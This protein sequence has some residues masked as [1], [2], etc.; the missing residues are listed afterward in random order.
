M[1]PELKTVLLTSCKISRDLHITE[2]D[3]S[4]VLGAVLLK[5]FSVVNMFLGILRELGNNCLRSTLKPVSAAL[6]QI[7][8]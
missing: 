1:F 8:N 7:T 3:F 4:N 5:S 2:S 6:Y